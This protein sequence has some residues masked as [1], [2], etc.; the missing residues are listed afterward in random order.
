MYAIRVITTL[1]A[2]YTEFYTA[3]GTVLANGLI[4]ILRTGRLKIALGIKEV[5]RTA[6]TLIPTNGS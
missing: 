3:P 5:A 1:H 4:S 2:C 6:T